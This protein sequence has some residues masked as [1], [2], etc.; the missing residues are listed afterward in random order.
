MEYFPK[1]HHIAALQQSPR[2]P[3][4]MSVEPEEFEGRII[5]MSMFND[6][7]WRSE[8]DGTGMRI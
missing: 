1:I 2:V 7:S 3:V 4:K 5:F 6:I 8:D